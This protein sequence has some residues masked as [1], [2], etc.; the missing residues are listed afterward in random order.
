MRTRIL[1]CTALVALMTI[2]RSPDPAVV[3]ADTPTSGVA[4]CD[5]NA[6]GL[7]DQAVGVPNEDVGTTVDAGAVDAMYGSTDGL[8]T[9]T[10]QGQ[11]WTQD[12]PGIPDQAAANNRFG[13]SLAC[14]DFNGDGYADLAVGAATE[15]V[16]G[17]RNAGAVNVLYGSLTGLQTDSPLA[18]LWTQDSPDVEGDAAQENRFG[19]SLIA[20]D[21][22]GDGFAD[23]VVGIPFEATGGHQRS[24][25]ATALYGSD[26]GLQATGVG[27]PDDQHWSQ[28]SVGVE[29]RAE[30]ADRFAWALAVADFN[31]DGLTDL[32]VGAPLE[33]MEALK[34]KATG[35]VNVLYGSA[36]GLQA[37]GV[38][39]PDDQFWTQDS[40]DV[41]GEGA[42]AR[43]RVGWS[44]AAGD[45][46]G[47][48]FGDLTVGVPFEDLVVLGAGAVN[49][50]YGSAPGLQATGVGG[51]DDQF[52]TQDSPGMGADG[53][54]A[55]DWF[56]WA[57]A[58][59]DFNAD[60]FRDL[61]IGVRVED[62]GAVLNAGAVDVLYGSATGLQATGEGGPDDQFWTQDSPGMAGDGAE[63]E[64]ELGWSL[65]SADFNGD[66]YEDLI[67]GVPLEDT[68]T[69]TD[70]GAV[71][72][73][74]GSATGLQSTGEGGLDDQF[75]TQDDLALDDPAETGDEFGDSLG[76]A[77]C[78]H[79]CHAPF[80]FEW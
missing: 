17:F 54:E 27:G 31:G 61:A 41:S 13:W 14:A 68:E 18:Q 10:P 50:L 1:I 53:A 37:T 21:F 46:N 62:V 43:D 12:S 76:D 15:G 4:V 30:S 19:R 32:A 35:A 40:P 48:G 60:G 29:D 49:V 80:P 2:I 3:A 38:G 9:S 74:Y 11:F 59:G 63:E 24:G 33:S 72:V 6:D 56:G 5:F 67:M 8:Q 25:A 55:Q 20:G 52:W 44:L 22:N 16:S 65:V 45:F 78:L 7:L 58:V 26:A 36:T 34:F 64:D 51:P 70:A 75:W 73:L 28:D 57:P 23:L 79:P 42:Q 66:T 39:G 69:I 77:A 71:N 47:D